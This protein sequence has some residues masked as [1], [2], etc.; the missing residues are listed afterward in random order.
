MRTEN[1]SKDRTSP[2]QSDLT[3]RGDGS[4]HAFRDPNSYPAPDALPYDATGIRATSAF[5]QAYELF[6]KADDKSWLQRLEAIADSVPYYS[7]NNVFEEL[8]NPGQIANKNKEA[9]SIGVQQIQQLVAEYQEF[10]NSLPSTQAQQ[11]SDANL[12]PL[13]QSFSGSNINPSIT[14]QSVG[15][16]EVRRLSKRN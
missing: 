3:F 4:G 1:N 9:I 6:S 15:T 11:F 8:F 2:K 10:V 14:P 5:K 13:T 16:P 7:A 12:N